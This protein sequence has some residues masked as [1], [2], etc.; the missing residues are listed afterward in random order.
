LSSAR[1]RF[2]FQ[3][4]IGS[5]MSLEQ[6]RLCWRSPTDE[7]FVTNGGASFRDGLIV[8]AAPC[9]SRA[10]IWRQGSLGHAGTS[11]QSVGGEPR[12]CLV[13]ESL[14]ERHLPP[15]VVLALHLQARR[16]TQPLA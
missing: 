2:S 3:R 4:P 1:F 5:V 8:S 16:V 14:Q 15:N 12:P 13:V 7:D 11:T 9:N 10:I 6:R